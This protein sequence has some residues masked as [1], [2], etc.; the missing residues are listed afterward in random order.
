MYT[1]IL[2]GL[3]WAEVCAHGDDSLDLKVSL[4]GLLTP[5]ISIASV[6]SWQQTINEIIPNVDQNT[7]LSFKVR[8]KGVIGG[9]LA[10]VKVVS[11]NGNVVEIFTTNP[12]SS[13]IFYSISS[14]V[15][16]YTPFGDGAW[17]GYVNQDTVECMN[18]KAFWIWDSNTRNTM[19]FQMNFIDLG[20]KELGAMG[21]LSK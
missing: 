15:T 9:F 11:Y 17:H 16:V 14:Q 6:T 8:D 12:I 5:P 19:I 1:Y 20:I 2:K 3:C 7:V 10:T 18:P 21:C 4:N 13:S